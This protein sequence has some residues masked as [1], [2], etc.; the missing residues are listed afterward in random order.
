MVQEGVW[1]SFDGTPVSNL[2][3]NPGQPNRGRDQNCVVI[4]R[5]PPGC[6]VPFKL[7][8][9]ECSTAFEGFLCYKDGKNYFLKNKTT[10]PPLNILFFDVYLLRRNAMEHFLLY[11]VFFTAS[12]SSFLLDI[13]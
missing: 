6:G 7:Q 11:V 5:Q 13:T 4:N 2:P 10:K 12:G 3:W 9:K 8:D 1:T